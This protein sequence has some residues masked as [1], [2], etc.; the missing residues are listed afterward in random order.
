MEL[1][2]V[3]NKYESFDNILALINSLTGFYNKLE[4]ANLSDANSFAE[5]LI[6]LNNFLNKMDFGQ[7][8]IDQPPL[9]ESLGNL[10][11]YQD[12]IGMKLI[13]VEQAI[14]GDGTKTAE[15]V[16]GKNFIE[17]LF[18]LLGSALDELQKAEDQ[19]EETFA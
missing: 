6:N 18:E 17:K 8:F 4:V 16:F 3:K 12:D 14:K 7:F 13:E 19:A 1:E 2:V 9:V 10:K 15:E 11:N 5:S